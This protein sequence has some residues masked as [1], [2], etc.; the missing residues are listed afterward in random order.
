MRLAT[1]AALIAAQILG[2]ASAS[3]AELPDPAASAGPARTGAFAGARLRVPLGARKDQQARL[4]L[5]LAPLQRRQSADGEVRLRFGEGVE[6][7]IAGREPVALRLAG[8]RLT[9]DRGVDGKEN[10]LGVSTIGAVAIGA[11]VVL[12]GAVAI[13]LVIR[14]GEDD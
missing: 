6:L 5:A 14:S 3:A 9:P 12:L 8:Q 11:G 10:R 7:E 4:G 2:A 1:A 13:A